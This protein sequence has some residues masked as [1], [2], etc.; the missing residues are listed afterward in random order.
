[1]SRFSNLSPGVF[2]SVG[3]GGGCSDWAF[4][5][6]SGPIERIKVTS[7]YITTQYLGNDF[8]NIIFSDL[9]I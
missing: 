1:M 3:Y 6:T 8:V 7:R 4:A 9:E 2:D 5:E